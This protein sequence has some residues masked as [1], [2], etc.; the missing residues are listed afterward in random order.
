MKHTVKGFCVVNE[1]EAVVFLMIQW[2]LE[3][4]L[5][6][7]LFNW[8]I[9]ALQNFAIFC[10][11]SIWISQKYTYIPSLLN[12]PPI[13]HPIPSLWMLTVWSLVPL[14]FLNPAYTS[15]SSQFTYCWSLTW[16]ILS[17]T[18]LVCAELSG[19]INILWHCHSLG[20]EWKLTFLSTVA[21]AE[22]SKFAGILS[23]ALS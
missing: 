13:S 1:V 12:L 20:L 6:N 10:Q 22:F 19:S 9:I 11:T 23:A 18:L 4:F 3:I 8:N 7:L 14:L 21:T 16:K 15:G 5:I 17:I 2:M